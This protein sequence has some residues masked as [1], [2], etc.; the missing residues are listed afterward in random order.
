M[1][2]S[3]FNKEDLAKLVFIDELTNLYNRRFFYQYLSDKVNWKDPS[4]GFSL[5]M[6]DI[7]FFKKINDTYGHLEGD[8]VLRQLGAVLKETIGDKGLAVRY[9]GDE[10]SAILPSIDKKKSLALAEAILK[11]VSDT[12]FHQRDTKA[13]PLA[14]NISIGIA[15]FPDDAHASQD[16]IEQADKALYLSKREGRN[17][18]SIAGSFSDEDILERN[19]FLNFPCPDFVARQDFYHEIVRF[20]APAQEANTFIL[21]EGPVGA[22]KSRLLRELSGYKDAVTFYN[23]CNEIDSLIPYRPVITF[24]NSLAESNNSLLGEACKELTRDMLS[25]ISRIVPNISKFILPH[26]DSSF[27]T[28]GQ[29]RKLLFDS[30]VTLLNLLSQKKPLLFLMDESQNIDHATL[31]IVEALTEREKGCSVIVAAIRDDYLNISQSANEV[32]NQFLSTISERQNYKRFALPL[33]NKG[34]TAEIISTIFSKKFPDQTF[35]DKI[36]QTTKGN[37]LFIEE[38]LKHLLLKDFIK[39]V[40]N[41][42]VLDLP[43][44]PP[45]IWQKDL[46][47][48]IAENIDLLEAETK[49]VIKQATVV[50]QN[51]P[52]DV[53]KDVAHQNE[54]ETID[55][56]DKAKRLNIIKPTEPNKQ[57]QFTFTTKHFQEIVYQNIEEKERETLHQAV[58]DATEKLYQDKLDSV[59][60]TL[61]FHFA[62]AGDEAKAQMYGQK[63]ENQTA[64]LFRKDEIP[65]YYSSLQGIVQSKIKE[66]IQPL[67][68]QKMA[69]VKDLL[70]NLL[71]TSKN[72]RLYPDGSQL[73]VMASGGLVKIMN[74]IFD[75]TQTFTLSEAKSALNINTTPLDV[76]TYGSA[77]EEFLSLLKEHYIKSIT[78]RHG[79]TE[80]EIERLL[81][82]L[83]RSPDKPFAIKGYWNQF[84]DDRGITNI[85]V[86]QRSFIAAKGKDAPAS[87]ST[88]QEKVELD[89]PIV[90]VLK[91][92]FRFFCAAVENIKLYPP[93]SQLAMEAVKFV[94]QSIENVFSHLSILNL[95]VSDDIL[96]VNGTPGHPRILG[97]A[98]T[99]LSKIIREYQLKSVSFIKGTT[100]EELEYFISILSGTPVD[101]AKQKSVKDWDTILLGK[102]IS[103]IKIG[104]MVYVTA[105]TSRRMALPTGLPGAMPAPPP[106]T[107][108]SVASQQPRAPAAAPPKP[109]SKKDESLTA[110]FTDIMKGLPDRLLEDESLK[111]A[112][113]LLAN[114]DEENFS[115]FHQKFIQN[116]RSN[117]QETRLTAHTAYQKLLKSA[118]PEAQALLIAKTEP[119]ILGE[120]PLERFSSV[121]NALFN[122][123]LKHALYYMENRGYSGLKNI[124]SVILK[125]HSEEKASDSTRKLTIST[126]SALKTQGGANFKLYSALKESKSFPEFLQSLFHHDDDVKN[127]VRSIFVTFN[128]V[129]VQD[130]IDLIKETDDIASREAV[131]ALINQMGNQAHQFFVNELKVQTDESVLKHLLGIAH[132][133]PAE[134]MEQ[135]LA[136]FIREPFYKETINALARLNPDKST[137]VLLPLLNNK[138]TNL[139]LSVLAVLGGL[140]YSK[141]VLKSQASS[142][143]LALMG[144]SSSPEIQKESAKTLVKMQE[145]KAIPVFAKMLAAKRFLGF[146]GGMSD[147]IRGTAAWA[148]GQIKTP[149]A[150][151]ALNSAINDK[152]PQVR[153][154]VKLSLK[155]Y[156]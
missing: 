149:E 44:L 133:I 102:G 136:E 32:F 82:N 18:V 41:Q 132:L 128:L 35:Y 113:E 20:L 59:A 63:T 51:V 77:V 83:D 72:M 68:P 107:P 125:R 6:M 106:G 143:I 148:L 69:L 135:T 156:E 114:S 124:I 2:I 76:K 80:Q 127:L 60:P 96:L 112:N 144:A 99:A 101:E 137:A 55:A 29:N 4:G 57:D 111:I 9:A 36:H 110:R 22:G 17:R 89:G 46:D 5:L 88:A 70:R 92:F 15:S 8:N 105:D 119:I 134:D 94:T 108:E 27:Q 49:T 85:G 64:N 42:W 24:I 122:S 81:K 23:S 67:S 38:L 16:L 34:Q 39:R 61:A 58:G 19:I 139:L 150:Q 25:E 12:K 62:K 54:G 116:L 117:R 37:P 47:T 153:S 50:G 95:S 28:T 13:A 1:D 33:F 123:A 130:L 154:I 43:S 93:G 53:L 142:A 129:A 56:L 152:S 98:S 71:S 14:I 90:G 109:A 131:A 84:L 126:T 141:P 31:L 118:Q 45:A 10:F 151:E 75:E 48:I 74:S 66:A 79:V 7:D 103:N 138:N 147:E 146:V 87:V 73:I 78:F 115:Q 100:K 91:D 21:V 140:Q 97:T 145:Q 120:I 65:E 30:L 121:Y 3:S 86:A 104:M 11:R 26:N 40:N 155:N 52:L